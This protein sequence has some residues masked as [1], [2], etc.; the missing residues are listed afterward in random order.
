MQLAALDIWIIALSL[1]VAFVPALLMA[2][3]AGRST[4]EFFTSGRAAPWWRAGWP[5]PSSRRQ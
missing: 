1:A 4:A 2:R 5:R 3:R